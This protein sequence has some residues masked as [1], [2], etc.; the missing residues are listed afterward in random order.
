MRLHDTGSHLHS[1]Q[2][3]FRIV[4]TYSLVV[5]L[6]SNQFIVISKLKENYQE[7]WLFAQV[8]TWHKILITSSL[9]THIK[10]FLDL[11]WTSLDRYSENLAILCIFPSLEK[12]ILSV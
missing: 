3:H 5:G 6:P 2:F 8:G 12:V 4:C 9:L 7:C 10:L 1:K 11:V